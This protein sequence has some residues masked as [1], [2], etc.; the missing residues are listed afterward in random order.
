TLLESEEPSVRWRVMV[1]ALGDDPS[2]PEVKRV[3]EEVRSSPRVAA[4]LAGRDDRGR[5]VRG[6]NVYAK[7]QGAHWVIAALADLGYPTGAEALEPIADQLLDFWLADGYF[8]E[9]ETDSK[10]RSYAK[11]GVPVMRG[12]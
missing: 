12:R 7:W 8:L 10:E 2:T 11:R 9:F 1:R 3:Q 4:L 5:F 6:R